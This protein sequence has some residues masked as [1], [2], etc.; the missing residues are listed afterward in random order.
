[1]NAHS[2]MIRIARNRTTGAITTSSM[3]TASGATYNTWYF[4]YI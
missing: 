3:K 2:V 1:M 4:W